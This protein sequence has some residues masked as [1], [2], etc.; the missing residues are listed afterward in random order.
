M[1]ILLGSFI[2]Q[3]VALLVEQTMLKVCY[4]RSSSYSEA[5][6]PLRQS[7]SQLNCSAARQQQSI[8]RLGCTRQTSLRLKPH[9]SSCPCMMDWRFKHI[10]TIVNEEDNALLTTIYVTRG[11]CSMGRHQR[12]WFCTWWG[13]YHWVWVDCVRGLSIHKCT[14]YA[15]IAHLDTKASE[16]EGEGKSSIVDRCLLRS[17]KRLT[18]DVRVGLIIIDLNMHCTVSDWHQYT[19]IILRDLLRGID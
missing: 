17:L 1:I 13:W 7:C 11:N 5:D 12:Q 9:I 8:L 4:S 2:W 19:I 15:C 14:C 10:T 16:Q 18:W 3:I 6:W